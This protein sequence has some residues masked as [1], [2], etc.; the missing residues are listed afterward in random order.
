MTTI[1]ASGY[2]PDALIITPA[3]AEAIDTMVS[4]LTGGT[5]DFVFGPGRFAPGTL[6]GLNVRVSKT[7]A[8]PIVVD[9]TAFGKLYVSPIS[10]ARFEV[11]AGSTNRS[12]VRLEGNA[13][14]GVERTPAAA[15]IMP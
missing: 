2:N 7:A 8:A 1:L 10:L 9:A 14:F 15:R 4:G 12:N 3:N 13:A 6:F 11:D 5:A